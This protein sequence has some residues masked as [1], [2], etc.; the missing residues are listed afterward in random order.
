[1]TSENEKIYLEKKKQDDRG[2]AKNNQL[3]PNIIIL[4]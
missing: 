4:L 3:I 2:S 1:M